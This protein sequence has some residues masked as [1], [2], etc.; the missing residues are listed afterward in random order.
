M[1]DLRPKTI[2]FCAVLALAIA[3]SVLLRGRRAVHWLFAAFAADIAL[4]YASQSFSGFFRPDLWERVTGVLTVLLPQ[5]AIH[6]FQ[7][8]VPREAGARSTPLARFAAIVGV[9]V[10]VVSRVAV[11]RPLLRARRGLHVRLRA[12]RGRAHHARAPGPAQPVAR[13]A[14]PRAL[15][16]RRRRGGDDLLA[17]R[18]P[19]VPRRA[20]AAHRRRAR[21][22]LP[23]RARRVGDPRAPRGHLRARGAAARLDRARLLPRRHL[24]PVRDGHRRLRDDVPERRPRRDRLPRPLRA[25]ADRGRDGGSTSSSSASA[26][27]SR[28]ASRSS[29]SCSRTCSRST[30]WSPR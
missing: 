13:R 15:P 11:P 24:L 23:L 8:V 21:D 2:L 28:R 29:A 27:T 6:L 30:R 10:L 22:R 26:T 9:P 1:E 25:A 19:L 3:L 14:R 20:P 16:R 12:A 5:F 18:L 4:W 7:N 17:R